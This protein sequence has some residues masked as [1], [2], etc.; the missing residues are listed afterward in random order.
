[1]PDN[2]VLYRYDC[3]HVPSRYIILRETPCGWWI[4]KEFLNIVYRGDVP[5]ECQRWVSK[6][7]R[8]RFAYPTKTEAWESYMARKQWRVWHLERQLR[9]AEDDLQNALTAQEHYGYAPD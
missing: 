7:G 5:K 6:T 1:M 9:T 8:K 3:P 4:A 2:E